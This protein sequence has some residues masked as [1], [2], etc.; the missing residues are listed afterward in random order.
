MAETKVVWGIHTT[1]NVILF[2]LTA[3]HCEEFI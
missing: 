3:W 2:R 1:L